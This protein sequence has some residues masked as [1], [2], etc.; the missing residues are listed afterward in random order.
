M[1]EYQ[2]W[3][4]FQSARIANALGMIATILLI[5]LAL[6][7]AV[8]TRTPV[9]GEESNTVAKAISSAFCL[10]SV[11]FVYNAWTFF[12][13]N[14]PLT[15]RALTQLQAQGIEISD[16]ATGFIDYVGTTEP[17]GVGV[18]GM[19]FLLVITVMMMA[20]IWMPKEGK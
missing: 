14:N 19:V 3:S 8:Q 11:F 2:I 16:I 18:P 9:S 1:E 10:L 7:T 6:R 20:Q 5:W 15:A 17:S 13:A 4:L 12:S